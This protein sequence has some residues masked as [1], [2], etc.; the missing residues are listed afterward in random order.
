MQGSAGPGGIDATDFQDWM[1]HYGPTS[2]YL[3]EAISNIGRLMDN[4][5]LTWAAYQ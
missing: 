2:W 1:L 5:V 4:T 3:H